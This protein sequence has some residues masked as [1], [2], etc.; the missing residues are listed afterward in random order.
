MP[1]GRG[2][3]F[4]SNSSRV[5]DAL[6]GGWRLS[7]IFMIQSG[8]FETPYFSNGDPSGSGSGFYCPQ[9][10]N[11]IGSGSVSNPTA[12]EWFNPAAFT[13]P[14]VSNW[15]PGSPCTIGDNPSSD[16]TVHFGGADHR[17]LWSAAFGSAGRRQKPIVCPTETAT[18]H[19][20]AVS[21]TPASAS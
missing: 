16:N 1:L 11:C 3:R 20:S 4:M 2:R 15:N 6:F 7:N 9:H 12:S 19:P 21:A 17:L 13:C 10:P 8:P 5:A 14:G 18:S